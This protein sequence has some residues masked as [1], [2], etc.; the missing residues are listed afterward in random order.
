M[1]ELID[2]RIPGE[3][4]AQGRP[5]FARRGK[6]MS[7]YDPPKS[8]NWKATAQQ[9]MVD[10]MKRR[11]PLEGPLSCEI[12]ATFTCPRSHWRKRTPQPVR[13]HWK[14]PDIENVAKA[15]LDA[16]TGVLWLDDAQV[17]RLLVVK[18]V[19]AQ[20]AAPG[21]RFQVEQLPE[22]VAGEYSS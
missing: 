2:I 4:C 22:E 13:L 6:F 19:G 17:A 1:P 16:A 20:G 8:R 3:P 9:H 10:A 15:V 14:T 11:R 5:R 18:L 7:A 21:L 12:V